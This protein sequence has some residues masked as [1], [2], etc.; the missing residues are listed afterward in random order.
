[1]IQSTLVAAFAALTVAA[2]TAVHASPLPAPA[3]A[4]VDAL[5]N[6]LQASGCE[7]NR[8]SPVESGPWLKA[9]LQQLRA[10]RAASAP[11]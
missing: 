7:F 10:A 1:M 11:R 6:R 4:D 3:R 8:K 9:E 2:A 5:L